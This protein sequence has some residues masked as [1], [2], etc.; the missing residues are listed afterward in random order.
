MSFYKLFLYSIIGVLNITP[1]FSINRYVTNTNDFGAG[2]L[3]DVIASA[4]AGDRIIVDVKGDI[5]LTMPITI[6]QP[7]E[8]IGAFPNHNKIDITNLTLNTYALNIT[9]VGAVRIKGF[10]FELS[11]ASINR[12]A[13][14][15]N[16]ASSVKVEDCNFVRCKGNNGGAMHIQ[17]TAELLNCAFYQ[18]STTNEG[19]A[20]RVFNSPS[21]KLI[22]CTFLENVS[23]SQGG[24]V[25]CEGASLFIQH[26]TFLES[27]SGSS[28]TEISIASNISTTV[29]NSIFN[30][31]STPNNIITSVGSPAW[32][33]HGGNI[34]SAIPGSITFI[35]TF[36]NQYNHNVASLVLGS[37]RK[38][39]YGLLFVP[40]GNGS[41]AINAGNTSIVIPSKDCRRAP[42]SM[43]G[44]LA[45]VNPDAG[46]FEKSAYTV[47]N[48]LTTGL[49]SFGNAVIQINSAA[50]PPPFYIDFNI[51][52]V[53]TINNIP[54]NFNVPV[55]I[56]GFTDPISII[57]GP[58][59]TP[60]TF[61]PPFHSITFSGLT[62][63][64]NY[65]LEF[66]PG[67]IGSEIYGL[68]IKDN[69]D[70]GIVILGANAMKIL[71]NTIVEN[72]NS[73]IT[74]QSTSNTLI[75]DSSHVFTNIISGNSSYGLFLV[76][77]QNTLIYNNIIGAD[78]TGFSSYA[79]LQSIGV[80]IFSPATSGLKIGGRWESD[81]GNVIAGQTDKQILLSG[82]INTSQIIGNYIGANFQ[83]SGGISS[84]RFGIE[85]NSGTKNTF[86][87]G[88]NRSDGNII[89][90]HSEI[91]IWI[92][93]SE[94]NE[95]L[96][97]LI[98]YSNFPTTNAFGNFVGIE[99][100][101]ATA[102][103]NI[104]G[105]AGFRNYVA[106][107]LTDGIRITGANN[108]II[109]TN[110]I[111][112]TDTG[113]PLSNGNN[114]IFLSV[115]SAFN[116]IGGAGG[117]NIISNNASNGIE[118]NLAGNGN[119]VM[120]N[121]IGLDTLGES[122]LGNTANGILISPGT[123]NTDIAGNLISANGQNGVHVSGDG[124]ILRNNLIGGSTNS[125]QQGN[126]NHGVFIT[127]SNSI[128]GGNSFQGNSIV[129]NGGDGVNVLGAASLNNGILSNTIFNNG[130]LGIDLVG[131]VGPNINDV[132][133]SDVGANNLFNYPELIAATDCNGVTT[134]SGN[135]H[136][137]SVGF[138]HIINLFQVPNG[139]QDPS[140]H[141]EGNLFVLEHSFTPTSAGMNYIELV[142]PFSI[143]PGNF[144][145][146]TFSEELLPGVFQTS[147]FSPLIT[148][149]AAPNFT[150]LPVNISCFGFLDGE[151]TTT[152]VA[153]S[154]SVTYTWFNS[155]NNVL[156]GQ[157]NSFAN[158]LGAD[159]YYVV[160]EDLSGC[161]TTSASVTISEPFPIT[162]SL[163]LNNPT[164]NGACNGSILISA[165]GGTG[166][167]QFSSDGG[168]TFSSV[169]NITNL[170]AGS[171]GIVI[172]D[173]NSCIISGGTTTL[174]T[175]PILGINIGA[176]SENC[177]DFCD[178]SLVVSG[179]GGQPSY[180]YSLDG[181]T[182]TGSGNFTSLCAGSGT[183][184]VQDGNNCVFSQSYFIGTNAIAFPDFTHSATCVNSTISFTDVTSVSSGIVSSWQWSFPTGTPSTS[185]AQNP[186]VLYTATGVYNIQLISGSATCRDTIV[187]PITV[188]NGPS[189]DAGAD[190]A[191]CLGSNFIYQPIVSGIGTLVFDWQ[192]ASHF[193]N[194]TVEFAQHNP[195]L[196]AGTFTHILT[197]TDGSGCVNSDAMILTVNPT[198]D[199]SF[200]YLATTFCPLGVG[201][202]LIFGDTGGTFS[203]SPGGLNLNPTTGQIQLSTSSPGN[204]TINYSVSNGLCTANSNFSIL[205][206]PNEDPNVIYPGAPNDTLR[207]CT[208]SPNPVPGS[209]ATPGGS[210]TSPGITV[211]SNGEIVVS[212]ASPG[213]YSVFYSTPNCG[214]KDTIIVVILNAPGLPISPQ[215]NFTYCQGQSISP[216][217]INPPGNN[218]IITWYSDATLTNVVGNGLSF[219]PGSL[220]G[221]NLFYATLTIGNCESNPLIFTITVIDAS[222]IDP[223]PSQVVCS[224]AHVQLN[225]TGTT[226]PLTWFPGNVLNDSTLVNP[227]ANIN[228]PT[229]FYINTVISGCNVTDSVFI[230][231]DNNPDCLFNNVTA[232]SPDGDGVNENWIIEAAFVHTNN[233][234]IIF[235]RWGDELV[236]FR[237]YNNVD[238][239]WDGKYKG[240]VLPSGTY[241]YV[242][243]YFDIEYQ[244]AGW[245]QLMR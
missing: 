36:L 77:T 104:I 44:G 43:N 122:A 69:I 227:I 229:M 152:Q 132:G 24:A 28:G 147:E 74:V 50:L 62:N 215:L 163:T 200:A 181:L 143:P 231:I 82:I 199:P 45:A 218:E 243:R 154:P 111:G 21:T 17:G 57:G 241:Y 139:S 58:G 47:T 72:S 48:N 126:S 35:P 169:S 115:G 228:N 196:S 109:R 110:Y 51:G 30:N 167:L 4:N 237:N 170:C 220:S 16:P 19:G 83:G 78:P 198:P 239:V 40:I 39:G 224:G 187:I 230:D 204:Y 209:I 177:K 131:N 176:T 162:S 194:N 15:I 244:L 233:Q 221:V 49:G 168:A 242:V 161:T 18:N 63:L 10:Q 138:N 183:V 149:Q 64:S 222:L 206:L 210:F 164:C 134:I 91:G 61:T 157:T 85:L 245:V 20:I 22:N 225:V 211:L 232:F 1:V 96:N 226:G 76:N 103:N 166:T 112:L 135:Y 119:V 142:V 88:N 102:I 116:I 65:F 184:F 128:V 178:G 203:A 95:V 5:F 70:H 23:T 94:G 160:T 46:A 87:G 75:G 201:M 212:S 185:N 71:G 108:N 150:L 219:L 3:R 207:L 156:T 148:V 180:T 236:R 175:P 155:L 133:D 80:G 2:S 124:T 213:I 114:G 193:V 73:G 42:R 208:S 68:K 67:A 205:I 140:G 117:K 84:T 7:I 33:N 125:S 145:S 214:N 217:V 97:N 189:V 188:T 136:V 195:T 121:F 27:T 25:R 171:Y 120:N 6:S 179:T 56:D 98:G 165:S 113:I 240:N 192:P 141:G 99:I 137:T 173:A 118:F 123:L 151:I 144:I 14:F 105:G 182:Y 92:D 90:S 32:N 12:G 106:G 86:I 146:A 93:Q 129:H 238:V 186:N 55:I 13:L 130:G 9:S 235:N 127:A 52:V 31:S 174:T 223:G 107:N 11:G 38:D 81:R 54:Y 190:T 101:G 216:L 197:V 79:T 29:H 89:I 191:I 172:Q 202:P 53:S 37:I 60:G 66:D 26:C 59:N 34:F 159:S 234:V 153:G 100:S 41:A 158:G 8:I